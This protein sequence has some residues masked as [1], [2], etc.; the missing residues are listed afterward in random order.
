[1][2][3]SPWARSPCSS[4]AGRCP[5]PGNAYASTSPMR[6][7]GI[8][9][10]PRRNAGDPG[11]SWKFM[12]AASTKPGSAV[13]RL[14]RHRQVGGAPPPSQ[15]RPRRHRRRCCGPPSSPPAAPRRP[16]SGAR[17][18]SP[19]SD[20]AGSTGPGN[21]PEPRLHG[22]V[23]HVG[24]LTL[25]AFSPRPSIITAGSQSTK[26]LFSTGLSGPPPMNAAR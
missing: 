12:A 3:P 18:S 26:M 5:V 6:S 22:H 24:A 21:P 13:T 23:D 11:R 4:S 17:R 25:L 1:M 8:R 19:A 20:S 14:S 10:N 15:P 16:S 9:L 2:A 7:K